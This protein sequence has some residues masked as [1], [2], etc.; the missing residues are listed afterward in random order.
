MKA[1]EQVRAARAVV[2]LDRRTRRLGYKL[3]R[4]PA[5]ANGENLQELTG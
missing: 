3:V 4:I 2:N 1:F 5:S